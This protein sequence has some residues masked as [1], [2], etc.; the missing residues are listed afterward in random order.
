MRIGQF[1]DTFL[2]I[3][4]GVGRV[5]YHFADTLANKGH[6]V[7][8]VAPMANPGP[9]GRYPFELCEFLSINVPLQKQYASGIPIADPHYDA[10]IARIPLDLIHVHSPF[11]AGQEAL[12]LARRRGIPVIGEF[13]SRYYDDF[14]KLTRAEML[15]SIGVKFIVS[16][17]EHCDEVWTV[18]QSSAE[19][20]ADYGYRGEIFV[21]ENGTPDV[22][23]SKTNRLLAQRTYHLPNDRVLLYCGQMNWKKN[24]RC[25][26]HACAFLKHSGE[27][28]TLVLAGQGP[29]AHAIEQE[30]EALGILENTVFTGHITDD[31]LLYGLYE[32][33]D[34]FLFPSLYDTSGMVVREAAAVETPSVVVHGSAPAEPIR[35]GEN[36]Y[37]C[38]DSPES[39]SAV[40]K[41]AFADR[42]KNITVGQTA[43]KTIY[44][45]WSAIID[46]AL[47]RY[48]MLLEKQ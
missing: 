34:L 27:H 15:A 25:I 21:L 43:R 10:R 23:P 8:V 45:S 29:D 3:V 19:V 13:H 40:I 11:V 44:T 30:A 38:S 37:L 47:D 1:T 20:L 28:F 48:E 33:A 12:R 36:G 26:L 46:K 6:D 5:V 16:F 22:M 31:S 39:L 9:L 32:A 35:D 4:D 17:Y 18:S 7:T 24:I 2:P 42:E 14:Y 41:R